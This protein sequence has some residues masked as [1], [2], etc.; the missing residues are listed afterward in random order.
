[1]GNFGEKIECCLKY[2]LIIFLEPF[3]DGCN[4]YNFHDEPWRKL[5][6]KNQGLSSL[7]LVRKSCD[8]VHLRSGW[9]RFSSSLSNNNG[10]LSSKCPGSRNH[11]GTAR[12]GWVNGSYPVN[13]GE[14]R[15]GTLQY[16]SFYCADDNGKVQIR[17]CGNFF[18]YKF[19]D[20]PYWSCEYGICIS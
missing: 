9:H 1:M 16:Y 19:I 14:I 8:A 4:N 20:I 13:Y 3:F 18:V 17:N 10:K 7:Q 6:N 2:A 12:P 11:C 15:T 5:T